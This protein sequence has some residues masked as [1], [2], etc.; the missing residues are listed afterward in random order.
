MSRVDVLAVLRRAQSACEAHTARTIYVGGGSFKRISDDYDLPEAIEAI[1]EV[2]AA[3]HASLVARDL[4]D[5]VAADDRLRAALAA[6][7][8]EKAK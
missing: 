3:A 4:A 1:A 5:Q 2:F 6:C 7:K 8:P